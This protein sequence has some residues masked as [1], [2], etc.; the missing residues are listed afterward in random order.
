[1]EPSFFAF[2]GSLPEASSF[3]KFLVEGTEAEGYRGIL[4]FR[5]GMSTGME[6]VKNFAAYTQ[7][8]QGG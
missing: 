5:N 7:R 8:Q 2:T 6:A 3:G 1:M 4:G